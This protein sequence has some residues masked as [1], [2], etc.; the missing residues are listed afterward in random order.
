MASRAFSHMKSSDLKLTR[1]KSPLK[2]RNPFEIYTQTKPAL[3][4]EQVGSM[5]VEQILA[6]AR[7]PKPTSPYQ[8]PFQQ[9]PSPALL[10]S[11]SQQ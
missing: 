5:T 1:N 9:Q 8:Q 7:K 6:L 4:A 10:Y 3:S 11:K 2:R